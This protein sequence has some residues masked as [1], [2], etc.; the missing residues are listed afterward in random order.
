MGIDSGLEFSCCGVFW[1]SEEVDKYF[2]FFFSGV[3]SMFLVVT[4]VFCGGYSYF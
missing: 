2:W 3:S 4:Y 1:V